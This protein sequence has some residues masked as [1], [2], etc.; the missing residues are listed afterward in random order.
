MT[1]MRSYY[2]AVISFP[3]I[4]SIS[5]DFCWLY[6]ATGIMQKR[7]CLNETSKFYPFIQKLISISALHWKVEILH[8]IITIYLVFMNLVFY[9]GPEKEMENKDQMV[10]FEYF[11]KIKRWLKTFFKGKSWGVE[12]KQKQRYEHRIEKKTIL[13][14]YVK[15]IIFY[16]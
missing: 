6:C 13:T 9:K 15:Y 12:N 11:A 7:N 3:M 10:E 8:K 14:L 16:E 2:H 5:L 4:L 1:P